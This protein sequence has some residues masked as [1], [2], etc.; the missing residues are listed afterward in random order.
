MA[1]RIDRRDFMRSVGAAGAGMCL[2]GGVP[3]AASREKLSI[4]A[5]GAGGR[6]GANV[7]AM[8]GENVVALCDID[9]QRASHAIG[10]FPDA[11][12]FVDYREL[13]DTVGDQLD[14]VVVSTPDHMHA[15][16]AV[17]AMKRG[18]HVYCEKP[19]TWSIEEARVLTELAAEKGLVTQM[20]NNGTAADGFRA[21]VEFLQSGALGHVSEV[22]V[23]TNRPI[24]AQAVPTPTDTPSVPQHIHWYL[25]LGCAPDRPYHKAYHPFSW[26]G[27]YDFGT[28][29]LGDMA[30]HTMN[31]PYMGLN[32]DAP[33]RVVAESTELF[34]D[35]YPKGCRIAY[36]FPARGNRGA[37]RFTWYD[38]SMAPPKGILGDREVTNSGCVV[39]GERGKLYSPNDNGSSFEL[40]PNPGEELAR[41]AASLPRSPGHH[42]EWLA[43]CRGEGTTLS[44]FSHAG[45]FTETVLLGNLALRVGKPILWDSKRLAAEG[46]PEA[47][48]L[49]R[50]AYR[51]GFSI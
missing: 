4:A 42:A 44:P 21:G 35:S 39:V 16:I 26:R 50:R 33:T 49:I 48:A 37:L 2:A 15:P 43:A 25:W 3:L 22:H 9:T 38:G 23:W 40:L 45:P 6:G 20:G 30:C 32:L 27:W 51:A 29:A 18:L 31:L 17:A 41:P 13:L 11:R 1:G 14:A 36:D 34:P 7:G 28:G 8:A 5:I 19:L 24:W 47:D 12:F 10:K 46:C